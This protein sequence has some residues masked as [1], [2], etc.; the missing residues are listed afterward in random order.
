MATRQKK[1]LLTQWKIA[2]INHALIE[3][4]YHPLGGDI[5]KGSLLAIMYEQNHQV[6]NHGFDDS[7]WYKLHVAESTKGWYC[8]VSETENPNLCLC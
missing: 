3:L 2:E 6:F 7:K 1:E 8:M 4:F 5:V